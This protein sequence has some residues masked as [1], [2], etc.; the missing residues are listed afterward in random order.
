MINTAAQA[1]VPVF[2]NI[3]VDIEK[4]AVFSLGA[5]YYQVGIASGKLAA[6]ILNGESS[7][8]LPI[9]NYAPKLLAI[10]LQAISQFKPTW[11][12]PK[13]WEEEAQFV[14]D[15]GGKKVSKD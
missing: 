10:N 2:S 15:V 11:N 12:F 8:Q 13:D 14:V 3:P 6:R 1:K 9:E 4:G 5:D 7:A